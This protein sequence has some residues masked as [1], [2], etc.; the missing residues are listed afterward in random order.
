[1]I[2][3]ASQPASAAALSCAVLFDVFTA[4]AVQGRSLGILSRF[5]LFPENIG[6]LI[7]VRHLGRHVRKR[8]RARMRQPATLCGKIAESVQEMASVDSECACVGACVELQASPQPAGVTTQSKSF[9]HL[10]SAATLL[11]S[12]QQAVCCQIER[13]SFQHLEEICESDGIPKENSRVGGIGWQ[14]SALNGRIGPIDGCHQKGRVVHLSTLL[15]KLAIF[16]TFEI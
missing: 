13:K 3:A 7:F 5:F 8:A 10:Q 15:A 9:V 11:A 14:L 1:M 16:S 6:P 2:W 12:R 4:D